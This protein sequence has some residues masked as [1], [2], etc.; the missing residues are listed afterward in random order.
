MYRSDLARLE[1]W[2]SAWSSVASGWT[3]DGSR[4]ML[5][6][7]ELGVLSM[8]VGFVNEVIVNQVHDHVVSAQRVCSVMDI[9]S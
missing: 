6:A 9:R 2:V 5:C 1:A 7:T 3:R 8:K 4:H